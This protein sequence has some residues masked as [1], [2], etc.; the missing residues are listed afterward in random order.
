MM[1]K[2]DTFL[3]C[4]LFGASL[5][6]PV[7]GAGVGF[8]LGGLAGAGIGLLAGPV[9]AVAVLAVY[10]G[11]GATA[12]GIKKLI[13]DKKAGKPVSL[14]QK[15]SRQNLLHFGRATTAN[16]VQGLDW[17]LNMALAVCTLGKASVDLHGLADK[18]RYGSDSGVA[19]GPQASVP[20]Q[21]PSKLACKDAGAAFSG[22]QQ[23]KPAAE[24]DIAPG[25]AQTRRHGRGL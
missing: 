16:M 13:A 25:K 10:A 17:A 20:S 3:R 6:S 9:A 19:P 11:A 22:A 14:R 24:Q 7:I 15:L 4:S 23:K 12:G 1:K 21:K 8:F 5:A 18:I 2:L